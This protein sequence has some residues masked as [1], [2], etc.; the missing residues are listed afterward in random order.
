MRAQR[1]RSLLLLAA[2][3]PACSSYQVTTEPVAVLTAQPAPAKTLLVT[4]IRQAT[5]EVQD[6]TVLRDTLFGTLLT[7]TSRGAPSTEPLRLPLS[8]I[9]KVEVRKPDATKTTILVV[10]LVGFVVAMTV[11]A[12]NAMDDMLQGMSI[13]IE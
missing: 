9:A 3:L 11:A 4:T 2:Y 7:V 6:P 10:A 8:E 5:L 13:P 12:S 1:L